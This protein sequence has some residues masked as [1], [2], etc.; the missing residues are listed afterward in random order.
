MEQTKTKTFDVTA[1]CAAQ[2]TLVEANGYPHFA[3]FDG[4]CYDCRM[5]IY[6]EIDDGTYKTGISV[7]SAAISLV[8]GCPH[9]HHSYC[10]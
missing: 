3:P 8:T 5:Q 10:D 7:E 6:T 1:A 9:C 2:K 4:K